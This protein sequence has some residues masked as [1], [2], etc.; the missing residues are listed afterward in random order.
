MTSTWQARAWPK[1]YNADE[2]R[3]PVEANAYPTAIGA[4]V[5]QP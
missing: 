4:I 1:P 5:E 2:K 3:T